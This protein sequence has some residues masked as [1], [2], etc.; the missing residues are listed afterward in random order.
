MER[1]DI[2]S[3]QPY[4]VFQNNEMAAMLVYQNNPVAVQL[5]SYVNTFLCFNKFGWLLDT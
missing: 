2:T 3:W 1:M 4:M 5:F